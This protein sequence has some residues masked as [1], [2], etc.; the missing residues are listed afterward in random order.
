MVVDIKEIYSV[1]RKRKVVI[2]K[3]ADGSFGFEPMKYIT[4]DFGDSWIPYGQYSMCITDSAESAE[5]EARGRCDWLAEDLSE[6]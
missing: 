2:Y 5:R 4:D 6:E 1:D 3:S